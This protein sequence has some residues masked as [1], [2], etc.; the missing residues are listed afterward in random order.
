M[1]KKSFMQGAAILAVAGLII[2]F[3]G[4]CF[5]IPLAN[6]IGDE[7]M[8]FYQT[9]YPVYVLFLT[10]STAGIPTAIS[11]MVSERAA[12]ENYAGAYRVFRVSFKLL[13]VIGLA[14]ATILFVAADPIVNYVGRPEARYSMMAIA[15][16]LLIVP[17]MAAY[18]GFFQGLQDMKPT[19]VSQVIEQLFRVICGLSLAYFLAKDSIKMAAAGAS[20]GATIG[21]LAGLLG[22]VYIFI[23]NRKK[24]NKKVRISLKNNEFPFE[25]SKDIIKKILIIA[26]PITIGASIMPIMNTIDLAIVQRR[27]I[28]IGYNTGQ[29]NKLYGQLT[30]LAGP[31]INFPQVL[32]QAIA[33]SL[34]PA[35]A[36]ARKVKDYDFLRHNVSWGLRAA[37]IVGAPCAFGLMA[38]SEPVMLT[39]YP[40]R[41][42][43]AISA[44][45]CLFVMAFGVIFLSTVQTLTGVLQGI[46][47]QMIP[48]RNLFIGSIAKVLVTYIATGIPNINVKGAAAGTVTAYIIASVLN[49]IAVKKYTKTKFNLK[50]TIIKPVLGATVMAFAAFFTHK[51]LN[52]FLGNAISTLIAIAIGG[53]VYMIMIIATRAISIEELEKLPKGK[54]IA[55]FVKKFSFFK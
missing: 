21:A 37:I 5:R 29:A 19:A 11:R 51:L 38:L 42:E 46:G 33:M 23:I 53:F 3:L 48:V 17:M 43:A 6:F 9:A 25:R 20:F 49:L 54:K 22:I 50:L 14:S 16:A 36:A 10:L 39:L 31:L 24:L 35:V 4:A 55:K 32:T 13:F 28:A 30:G 52:I 18:R 12:V 34:V 1:S 7:G 27:L 45:P 47:K 41:P 2:K 15:P 8:G 26:I 44:A 40:A